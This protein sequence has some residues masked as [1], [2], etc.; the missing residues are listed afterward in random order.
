MELRSIT[1]QD[2]QLCIEISLKA[3]P[4]YVLEQKFR[5]EFADTLK[6]Y[7]NDARCCGYVLADSSVV[8]GFVLV[9]ETPECTI[10]VNKLALLPKYSYL[11]YEK[12][13]LQLLMD[14]FIGRKLAMNV[15]RE[16]YIYKVL[17]DMGFYDSSYMAYMTFEPGVINKIKLL[18][19]MAAAG[20]GKMKD[21]F[22]AA[23][24]PSV[25]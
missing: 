10:S 7:I 3:E 13:M 16:S 12:L 17:T 20:D 5:S 24:D 4:K 8:M 15:D 11:G 21:P 6:T 14:K 18:L 19:E 23:N 25:N 2:I 1:E 9:W 22:V